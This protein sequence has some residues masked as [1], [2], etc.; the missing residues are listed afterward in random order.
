MLTCK[1]CGAE[2]ER[3]SG[4]GA[5]IR[6]EHQEERDQERE[7]KQNIPR[8]S[9]GTN[10]ICPAC[11][12]DNWWTSTWGTLGHHN[13]DKCHAQWDL[14]TRQILSH[15]STDEE[16]RKAWCHSK[17]VLYAKEPLSSEEFRAEFGHDRM[18]PHRPSGRQWP[19]DGSQGE[20]LD[21]I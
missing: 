12:H 4:L 17:A 20:H 5:H 14:S 3:V 16:F 8:P 9:P 11:G 7:G 6:Y 13:C 21:I 2:F 1:Y 10:T 19:R 15:P 18:A